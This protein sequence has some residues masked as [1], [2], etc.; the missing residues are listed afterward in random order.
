MDETH[1]IIRSKI[2]TFL[3]N[4][5]LDIRVFRVSKTLFEERSLNMFKGV[6]QKIKR[7]FPGRLM[8][9]ESFVP[10]TNIGNNKKELRFGYLGRVSYTM[11]TEWY[12]LDLRNECGQKEGS[13]LLL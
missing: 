4:L 1:P 12:K 6:D 13:P 3:L 9:S 10:S 5:R 2:L 7:G 11:I 8:F